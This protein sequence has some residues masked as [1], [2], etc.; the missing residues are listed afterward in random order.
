MLPVRAITFDASGNILIGG[1]F[2]T[3]NNITVSNVA[4]LLPSGALDTTFN[5][6]PMDPFGTVN[7]VAVDSLN[8][9]IIGGSFSTVNG[10]NWPGLARLLSSGALDTAF[11]PGTDVPGGHGLQRGGAGAG[12]PDS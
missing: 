4:R 3:F 7:A 6:G 1:D 10:T 12:Q 2:T 11:N 8:N 9:I 5:P